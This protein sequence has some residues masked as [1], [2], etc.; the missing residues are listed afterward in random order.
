MSMIAGKEGISW[1][2]NPLYIHLR[3]KFPADGERARGMLFGAAGRRRAVGQESSVRASAPSSHASASTSMLKRKRGRP[4]KDGSSDVVSIASSSGAGSANGRE[5]KPPPSRPSMS[6]QVRNRG[7]PLSLSTLE[8]QRSRL[9][10]GGRRQRHGL[11][12]SSSP[13]QVRPSTQAECLAERSTTARQIR[14]Q[15]RRRG[16]TRVISASNKSKE[17]QRH[18]SP[19]GK[20]DRIGSE[21][22]GRR[23]LDANLSIINFSECR[24]R[25]GRRS[26]RRSV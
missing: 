11:G 14:D 26:R 12:A 2:Q 9:G 17:K 18:N 16:R 21:R 1:T 15:R 19:T 3:T 8:P 6:R 13:S 22:I 7:E 10:G 24:P 23:H 5:M 20:Q 4:R 25:T